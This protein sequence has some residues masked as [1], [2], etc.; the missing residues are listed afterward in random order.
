MPHGAT[1][2]L[3]CYE[4]VTAVKID[5]LLQE[6]ALGETPMMKDHGDDT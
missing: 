1:G 6:I 5:Q 3:Q 2:L 4:L